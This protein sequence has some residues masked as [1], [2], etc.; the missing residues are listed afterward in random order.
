M[1]NSGLAERENVAVMEVSQING[2]FAISTL[3][4]DFPRFFVS[5]GF[6]C[7]PGK[8]S[9]KYT[10][11][12]FCLGHE[13]VRPKHPCCRKATVDRSENAH[14][15]NGKKTKIKPTLSRARKNITAQACETEEV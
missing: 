3:F 4:C 15:C 11:L 14:E 8:T 1:L 2:P 10:D 9:E 5:P 7:F 6:A 13:T 12:L